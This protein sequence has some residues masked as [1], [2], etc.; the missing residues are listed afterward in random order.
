[1]GV[2]LFCTVLFYLGSKGFRFLIVSVGLFLT[3]RKAAEAAEG[4]FGDFFK[5]LFKDL[6]EDFTEDFSEEVHCLF[7]VVLVVVVSMG[8]LNERSCLRGFGFQP[9]T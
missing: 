7:R 1:M 5:D 4:E 6:F 3:G 8:F 9:S 2:G